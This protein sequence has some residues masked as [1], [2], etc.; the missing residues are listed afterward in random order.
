[1]NVLC[2]GETRLRVVQKYTLEL[3]M[4]SIFSEEPT[5]KAALLYTG[6]QG[7]LSSLKLVYKNG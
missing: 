1:M 3:P 7:W 2:A 4:A 6:R 5:S